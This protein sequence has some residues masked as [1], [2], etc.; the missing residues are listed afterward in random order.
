LDGD[1]TC[2]VIVTFSRACSLF[3]ELIAFFDKL[4]QVAYN[5]SSRLNFTPVILIEFFFWY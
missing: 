4:I 2:L 3:Y 5:L 1:R